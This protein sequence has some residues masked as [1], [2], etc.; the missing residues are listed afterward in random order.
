MVA[1]I[2]R[3]TISE[4]NA[5]LLKLTFNYMAA[6]FLL[7]AIAG[8]GLFLGYPE[9]I[10]HTSSGAAIVGVYIFR[11]AYKRFNVTGIR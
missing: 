1:Q 11:D 8:L 9:F 5:R 10:L 3:L 6:G 4:S 2:D 7:A